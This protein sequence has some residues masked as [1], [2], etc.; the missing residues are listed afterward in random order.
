MFDLPS[1]ADIT[2]LDDLARGK[3]RRL[4]LATER[5]IEEPLTEDDRDA[6]MPLLADNTQTGKKRQ[7]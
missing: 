4:V 5:I 7:T 6:F 2:T 3:K 1:E